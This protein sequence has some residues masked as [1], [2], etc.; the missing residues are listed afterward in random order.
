M[1]LFRA[2]YIRD[3]KPRGMTFGASCPPIA[4]EYAYTVLQP[5][6]HAAGG[7]DIL[8]VAPSRSKQHGLNSRRSSASRIRS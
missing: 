7:G 8:T 6:I 2:V 5:Y 3:G 4:A 1:P